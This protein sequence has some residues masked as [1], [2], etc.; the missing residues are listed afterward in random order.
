M[1]R[2]IDSKKLLSLLKLLLVLC[3]KFFNS[4]LSSAY[5]VELKNFQH[6]TSNNFSGDNN[7]TSTKIQMVHSHTIMQGL[8]KDSRTFAVSMGPKTTSKEQTGVLQR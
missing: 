1:C 5:P 8:G 2:L 4:I 3:W 7:N 6:D